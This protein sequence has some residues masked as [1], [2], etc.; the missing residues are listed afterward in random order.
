[1][2]KD[3][4]SD[5]RK[6]N[7]QISL[8]SLTAMQY[9]ITRKQ[10]IKMFK[11]VARRFIILIPQLIILSFI[12]FFLSETIR[13][14]T[15]TGEGGVGMANA[16]I[17]NIELSTLLSR[18]W[19]WL[20]EIVTT[21]NLGWS[22]RYRAPVME[23][24][25]MRLPNTLRLSLFTLLL[26][27][28]IGIPL[29]I[30]SGRYPGTRKDQAIQVITQIGASFPSFTLAILL[31]LFFG[32]QFRWFP[33]GGSLSPGISRAAGFIPYHM[34]RLHHLML[35][36]L[37]L[38]II[39][40]IA[41]MKYL[42][43]DIIDNEQQEFVALA[44]AKGASEKHLFKKHIFKNSLS[45]LIGS[46][47]IQLATIITGSII[48]ESIFIFPGIGDLFYSAFARSD[49]DVVSSSILVFGILIL[50]GA[51]ISD[52]LLIALDPR[53]KIEE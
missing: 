7:H 19:S 24:I 50:L 49:L 27:Y 15:W 3:Q 47:P 52:I 31:L 37:S 26:I 41:P 48:I 5:L 16:F 21:G 6:N 20:S 51:F 40:L 30:I 34:G 38:A 53:I 32:F 13:I 28:G 9:M 11:L 42:R 25:G 23:V 29:G 4:K 22:S 36:A 17:V 45:S 8:T 12:V 39:Q 44:R 35:P 43:S 46:F 10:V 2:I 1:M 14:V 33:T 18:Y